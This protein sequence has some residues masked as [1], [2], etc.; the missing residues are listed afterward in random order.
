MKKSIFLSLLAAPFL[1]AGE[2]SP[3]NIPAEAQWYLHAD[4]EKL[5]DTT[6]GKTIIKAVKKEHGQKLAD[7]EIFLGFD[8]IRDITDVSLFGNGKTDNAAII[9]QGEINRRHLES[10]I[11]DA[12]QYK[13]NLYQGETIHSWHD[14][15]K[16]Q[17]AAFHGDTLVVVSQKPELI[18]LTLDVLAKRKPHLASAK[19]I[20]GS[21]VVMGTANIEALDLPIDKGSKMLKKASSIS[22]S[23]T[24]VDN[25]LRA[26]LVISTNEEKTAARL[27]KIVEGLV[28]FGL[29]A[30][31]KLEEFNIEH[32][33]SLTGNQVSMHLTIPVEEALAI[34]GEI[35]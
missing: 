18:M 10:M 14:K 11:V 4:V 27:Q 29:M 21:S 17:I 19:T 24:E 8:L 35:M 26:D 32:G 34:L 16:N 5:R 7:A 13:S 22:A 25:R 33:T 31:P 2:F 12:D 15:G 9:I 6:M 28:A 30:E 3:G 20:P 1:S 23:L